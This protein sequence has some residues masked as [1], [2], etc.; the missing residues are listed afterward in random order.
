MIGFADDVTFELVTNKTNTR[1]HKINAQRALPLHAIDLCA[2][3]TFGSVYVYWPWQFAVD[4]GS[5]LI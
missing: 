5:F 3:V 1:L 4:L 2:C